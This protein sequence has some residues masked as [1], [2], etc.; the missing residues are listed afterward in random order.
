MKKQLKDEPRQFWIT[1]DLIGDILRI[2]REHGD[3]KP[4]HTVRRL[5]RESISARGLAEKGGV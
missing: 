1:D 4:S 2:Q 3:E 5:L